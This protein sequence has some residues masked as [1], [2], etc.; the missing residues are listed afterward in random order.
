[1]REISGKIQFDR[2]KRDVRFHHLQLYLWEWRLFDNLFSVFFLWQAKCVY[3]ISESVFYS[4]WFCI[5]VCLK[6]TVRCWFWAICLLTSKF[7]ALDGIVLV[8]NPNL[9]CFSSVW[10]HSIKNSILF[11]VLGCYESHIFVVDAIN[12]VSLQPQTENFQYHLQGLLFPSDK[13][14]LV[15]QNIFIYLHFFFFAIFWP[16]FF[17][18]SNVFDVTWFTF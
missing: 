9:G 5:V 2:K 15:D 14:V 3:L 4:I 7:W 18:F 6:K 16:K 10:F 17:V 13:K 1:M 12:W 11:W 8:R